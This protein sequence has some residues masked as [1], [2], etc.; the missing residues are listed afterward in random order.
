MGNGLWAAQESA[1]FEKLVGWLT[2]SSV[3]SR[4]SVV[5]PDRLLSTLEMTAVSFWGLPRKTR[6][7]T[8]VPKGSWGLF[9]L[10]QSQRRLKKMQ[11]GPSLPLG[12]CV[13]TSQIFY[14]FLQCL[15]CLGAVHLVIACP[16]S[17]GIF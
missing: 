7:Q 17:V 8:R 12:F 16:S 5:P 9:V 2:G 15:P 10:S 13:G 3:R 14:L 4:P 1:R 11:N 6:S